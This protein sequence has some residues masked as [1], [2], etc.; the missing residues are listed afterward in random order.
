MNEKELIEKYRKVIKKHKRPS[1]KKDGS[2]RCVTISMKK[3]INFIEEAIKESFKACQ[4]SERE[5]IEKL[6]DDV[7]T[8]LIK[9]NSFV[10]LG[11]DDLLNE[12]SER[13]KSKI[14]ASER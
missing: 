10:R 1:L 12:F 5:R 9:D 4:E 14:E 3:A 7:E 13:L 6:I 11:G 2:L 8:S